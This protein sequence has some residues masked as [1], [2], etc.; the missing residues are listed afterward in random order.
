MRKLASVQRIDALNPIENADAIEVADIL[1]WKVVVKK[2]EFEVGDLCVYFEIDSVLPQIPLF[3]FMKD[4]RYRVRTV[5]LRGQISQGLAIPVSSILPSEMLADAE[6]NVGFDVTEKI[7]VV[8]YEPELHASLGG[9]TLGN[10]PGFISK[11]DEDR[12][13]SNPKLFDML[14][15][16]GFYATEKLD[17]CSATYYKYEGHFGV[18]SRNWELKETE[19]N[20]YWRMA[21]EYDLENIL[22]EGYFIQGEII[23]PNVQSNRLKLAKNE[24]RAFNV[25]EIHTGRFG[26]NGFIDFCENHNLL[27]VPVIALEPFNTKEE[28]IKLADGCSHL[29]PNELAEGFVIRTHDGSISF[30]VISNEYLLK[31]KV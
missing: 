27:T 31:Y 8:K 19:T 14:R 22:P 15:S 13:Q 18:C 16:H 12:I 7:G 5:K 20:L 6:Y 25:G 26:F 21:K 30:K 17:G 3:E 29:N 1:G 4:R 9:D 11:T 10:F 23:G 28:L 2:G 24:F